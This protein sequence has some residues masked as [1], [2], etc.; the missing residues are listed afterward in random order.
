[1]V[2]ALVLLVDFSV[3]VCFIV[4]LF[5]YVCFALGCRVYVAAIAVKLVFVVD[6]VMFRFVVGFRF[7]WLC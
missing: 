2:L 4:L 5:V 6:D 3:F 1:M 7:D